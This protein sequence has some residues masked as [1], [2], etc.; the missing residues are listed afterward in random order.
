MPTSLDTA[1]WVDRQFA[2][3]IV[4]ALVE[5]VKIPNKS[6]AF[7][8]SWREH[9]HMDR[10]A[11]LLADWARGQLPEGATLEVLR[12]GQRTPVIF[13]DI[14]G[15]GPETVMLYG[16]FDKQPETS[17]WRQG[18]GP[19]KPVIEG[20]KLYGRGSADDGY[21]LFASLTAVNALRR[22]GIPHARCVL[23][24]EGCEESGSGDLPAYIKHL[25][26]RVGQLSLVVCLDS[27][28]ANYDQLWCTTS[29]RGVVVGNLE[30]SLLGEGVHSGDG[31]GIVASSFRVVRKLLERIEDS[32]SGRIL[33]P[34]LSSAISERRRQEAERVAL[35][36]G[37]E[38]WNKFPLREGVVPVS[39]DNVELILNRSWRPGLAVTGADG[40][41]AV[42]SG[43]NVLRPLTKLTLSLRVPPGVD[44]QAALGALKTE[45]ERDPPYGASVA[46]RDATAAAGWEAPPLSPWL[47]Q[48]LE[49]ASQRH[50]GRAAMYMGEGGTI[51]FM[52][53][54]GN[55]FPDAQF[56]ITGVL[57]PGSNAHGPNEFLHLPTAQKL[58]LCVADTLAAHFARA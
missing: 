37:D 48:A 58:T 13:I 56:C 3:S 7:D 6:P 35:V 40:I 5:Y 14:P 10:A 24:I 25:A 51:P 28:C 41:P 1:R 45:L 32:E 39:R 21:A 50:F 9:G 53:M 54:L 8:P 31:T 52:S 46:F 29:L 30:V 23:L 20:D 17:G 27:G 15:Q 33:L 44:V 38:V 19:W 57:G 16:H 47:D 36:L 22:E 2:E 12:L 42:G 34:E 26:E 4:P 49:A 18:L 11:E 43:G 55:S